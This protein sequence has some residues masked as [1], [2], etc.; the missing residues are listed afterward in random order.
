MT[1]PSPLAR[2]RMSVPLSQVQLGKVI[3]KDD[4]TISNWEKGV[5]QARLT[6]KEFKDLCLALGWSLITD[7][8]DRFDRD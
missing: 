4:Q 7:I 3:D 1:N 5:Y 8:P 2:R 6:P